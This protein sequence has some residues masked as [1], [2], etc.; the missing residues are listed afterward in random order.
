[1][2]IFWIWKIKVS[3]IDKLLIPLRFPYVCFLKWN[4]CYCVF[5]QSNHLQNIDVCISCDDMSDD[6]LSFFFLFFSFF[7]SFFSVLH[8]MLVFSKEVVV[9][10]KWGP[11]WIII[12]YFG[13]DMWIALSIDI[14]TS[15]KITGMTITWHDI[16][17]R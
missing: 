13:I 6:F 4:R 16:A 5:P 1:M 11:L 10:L 12:W 15:T 3:L 8:T 2:D 7:F 17:F 14:K 9:F